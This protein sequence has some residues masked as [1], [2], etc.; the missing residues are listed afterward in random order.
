MDGDAP[1]AFL[2]ICRES[3]FSNMALGPVPKLVSSTLG[4]P[5]SF[6]LP[7]IDGASFSH[8]S[9]EL[10]WDVLVDMF[11]VSKIAVET[12]HSE[13]TLACSRENWSREI[14]LFR[15]PQ[16]PARHNEHNEGYGLGHQGT[17]GPEGTPRSSIADHLRRWTR[18][19]H[20]RRWRIL[21]S[22]AYRPQKS[23]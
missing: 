23:R 18:V 5:F 1:A 8:G 13:N 3:T 10:D 6:P 7:T 17:L 4:K 2:A 9:I 12:T 16:Q 19:I 14:F 21:R 22:T 11:S 15:F 20:S